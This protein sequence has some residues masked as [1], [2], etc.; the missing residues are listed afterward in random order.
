M[1]YILMVC[2]GA[3]LLAVASAGLAQRG[4]LSYDCL[5]ACLAEK[6]PAWTHD[7]A[8]DCLAKCSQTPARS[9]NPCQK[10]CYQKLKQCALPCKDIPCKQKC[11]VQY[12][13]CFKAC[14]K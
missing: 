12:M 11:V 9:W 2:V 13:Q 6:G 4:D 3:L 5:Q 10:Q 7:D 1:K 14:P 8:A